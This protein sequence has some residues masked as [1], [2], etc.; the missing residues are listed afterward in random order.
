VVL[1]C[2]LKKPFKPILL[3]HTEDIHR[4][5][6]PG[7][8]GV[9]VF[10]GNDQLRVVQRRR[11]VGSGFTIPQRMMGIETRRSFSVMAESRLQQ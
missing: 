1:D 11:S 5:L 6:Q 4:G 2:R 3:I 9:S 8:A 7:P 10:P